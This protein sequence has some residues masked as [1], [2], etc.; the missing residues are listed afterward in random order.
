MNQAPLYYSLELYILY[1]TYFLMP[2]PQTLRTA[3]ASDTINNVSAPSGISS[4]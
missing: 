2:D 1:V 4:A 3:Y